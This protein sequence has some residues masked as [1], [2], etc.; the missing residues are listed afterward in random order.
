MDKTVTVEEAISKGNR[1]VKY[2][3]ISI[4][5]GIA[6]ITIYL[7]IQKLIPGW[8]YPVG[9]ALA[10]GMAW[11]WWKIASTKWQSWAFQN[12]RNV[13][14]LRKR[15]VQEILIGAANK[16]I[17][18]IESQEAEDKEKLSA[19]QNKFKQDDLFEDDLTIPDETTIYY[20]KRKNRTGI[21]IMSICLIIGICGFIFSNIYI[22]SAITILAGLYFGLKYYKNTQDQQPQIIL[23]INGIQTISTKHFNWKE[24][25][26]DQVI[27]EQT[28]I[29]I[30]YFLYYEHPDGVEHLQID[31]YSTDQRNLSRLLS[32]YRERSKRNTKNH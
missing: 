25:R 10:Y 3:A 7:G 8:S 32:L 11:L 24:I 14:E 19:L 17:E 5:I 31:H 9:V 13:H 27:V 21:A 22:Y 6:V 2:P 16:I 28:D 12:V 30:C 29:H 26:N 20:S 1:I 15:A 23:N 4:M 18:T